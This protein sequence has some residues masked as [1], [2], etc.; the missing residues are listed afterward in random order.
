MAAAV[1][2]GAGEAAGGLLEVRKHCVDLQWP[3]WVYCLADTEM[4]RPNSASVA[5]D[6]VQDSAADSAAVSGPLTELVPP[7]QLSFS[8]SPCCP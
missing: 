7:L 1:S 3:Q 8:V 2:S 6:G 5:H 4:R